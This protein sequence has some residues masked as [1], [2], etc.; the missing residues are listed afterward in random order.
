MN[1]INIVEYLFS[2][3]NGI[4]LFLKQGYESHN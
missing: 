2:C 3:T 4:T 1:F